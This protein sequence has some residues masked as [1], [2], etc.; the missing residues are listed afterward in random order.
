LREAFGIIPYL[1]AN[2][3]LYDNPLN[4]SGS[5]AQLQKLNFAAGTFVI[6]PGTDLHGFAHMLIHITNYTIR[7]HA[8]ISPWFLNL[9]MQRAGLSLSP[10]LP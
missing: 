9:K 6:N 4:I 1:F 8:H 5:I 2:F 7:T 10:A 3:T